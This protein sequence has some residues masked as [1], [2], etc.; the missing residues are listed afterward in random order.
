MSN[1][2]SEYV[3]IKLVVNTKNEAS[4]GLIYKE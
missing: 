4:I 2:E 1:E 3:P